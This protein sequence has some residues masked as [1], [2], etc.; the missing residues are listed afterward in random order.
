MATAKQLQANRSNAQKS[1]GPKTEAGKS[2]ARFNALKH[3]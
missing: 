1:T 2:T 3:A